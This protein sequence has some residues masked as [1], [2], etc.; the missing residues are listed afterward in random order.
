MRNISGSKYL[1]ACCRKS[2]NLSLRTN[3]RQRRDAEFQ[4][5][6]ATHLTVDRAPPEPT[7]V[8]S[9]AAGGGGLKGQTLQ[10]QDRGETMEREMD[11]LIYQST[12]LPVLFRSTRA[13]DP[14]AD[15]HLSAIITYQR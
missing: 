3:G 10:A 13:L 14:V 15:L 9:E 7:P 8:K 12:W 5:Q 6:S 1:A 11:L 2:K 4:R